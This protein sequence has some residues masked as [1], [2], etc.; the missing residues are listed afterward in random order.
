MDFWYNFQ[1]F[2]Q[3]SYQFYFGRP[4]PQ[5][6]LIRQLQN[7]YGL[8]IV[9]GLQKWVQQMQNKKKQIFF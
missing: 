5:H 6:L 1:I 8:S 9:W 4:L 2:F 7:I 3:N